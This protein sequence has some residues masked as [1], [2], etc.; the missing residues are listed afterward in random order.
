MRNPGFSLQAS[1]FESRPRELTRAELVAMSGGIHAS[2]ARPVQ[3]P[4]TGSTAVTSETSGD[5]S[6][7]SDA[8]LAE[9][10]STIIPD[11]P[12][13]GPRESRG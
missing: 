4:P 9:H 11:F 13:S 6:R 3:N 12:S 1:A 10:A 5:Q 7:P 2:D 8:L